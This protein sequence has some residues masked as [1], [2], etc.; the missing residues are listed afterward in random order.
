MY[1]NK[2][3]NHTNVQYPMKWGHHPDN[4][5]YVCQAKVRSGY[6][7]IIK[8][9]NSNNIIIPQLETKEMRYCPT[10]ASLPS[11]V[12]KLVITE[13]VKICGNTAKCDCISKHNQPTCSPLDLKMQTSY[14]ALNY[15]TFSCL[16]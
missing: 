3:G 6:S 9:T 16:R 2:Q 5:T 13:D 4:A 1:M 12:T 11:C 8:L 14:G 7:G 10:F 15:R